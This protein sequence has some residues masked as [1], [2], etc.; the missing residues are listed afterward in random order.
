MSHEIE[1]K[2]PGLEQL[3]ALPNEEDIAKEKEIP[4]HHRHDPPERE[5]H[6]VKPKCRNPGT[7]Q[8]GEIKPRTAEAVFSVLGV[9]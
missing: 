5:L 1:D 3:P 4:R 9:A 7:E 8:N 2:Y 6:A